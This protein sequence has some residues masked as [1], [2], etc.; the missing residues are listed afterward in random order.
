MADS[1]LEKAD[2]QL[3]RANN[4]VNVASCQFLCGDTIGATATLR[5]LRASTDSLFNPLMVAII[6]FNL[7]QISGDTVSLLRSWEV[8]KNNDALLRMRPLVAAAIINEDS[9]QQLASRIPSSV[10]EL[11][12]DY[13]YTPEEYLYITQARV[14]MAIQKGDS[15]KYKDGLKDYEKAVKNYNDELKHNELII[16]ETTRLIGEAQSKMQMERLKKERKWWIILSLLVFIILISG[17]FIMT[18]I[19][20]FKR[21][22]ML[23][24]LEHERL[25]RTKIATELMLAEKETPLSGE[26]SESAFLRI[27]MDRYP[28]VSKAGRR[29]ATMI[30]KGYDT[31]DIAKALNVRKESVIQ[32][33]WRLRSQMNLNPDEDLE[34]IIH[35]IR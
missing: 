4:R 20:R 24:Q 17:I 18:M 32:G 25:R 29:L 14:N 35:E 10:L 27:F 9:I 26:D 21:L 11:S 19:Q 31:S 3:L 34:V 7:H 22:Q 8:V 13:A 30:W 1:L 23:R 5:N 15:D 6:D 2:L 28:K 12:D 16:A 33:R